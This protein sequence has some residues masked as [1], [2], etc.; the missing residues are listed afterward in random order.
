MNIEFDALVSAEKTRRLLQSSSSSPFISLSEVLV[1]KFASPHKLG[2][3]FALIADSDEAVIMGEHVPIKCEDVVI[4]DLTKY[5]S[6]SSSYNSLLKNLQTQVIARRPRYSTTVVALGE[7][8]RKLKGLLAVT[9]H[10][11]EKELNTPR[12][13][14][15]SISSDT[16]T[17]FFV[18][19]HIDDTKIVPAR[20]TAF[21]QFPNL[22]K[23]FVSRVIINTQSC[24][25]T[26]TTYFDMFVSTKRSENP[27]WQGLPDFLSTKHPFFCHDTYHHIRNGNI[28]TFDGLPKS[29]SEIENCFSIFNILLLEFKLTG[30]HLPAGG[31]IDINSYYLLI[32]GITW[33]LSTMLSTSHSHDHYMFRQS[34]V[35]PGLS[36]LEQKLRQGRIFTAWD[37]INQALFDLEVLSCISTLFR[38]ILFWVREVKTMNSFM[39]N[40]PKPT[41]YKTLIADVNPDH[42]YIPSIDRHLCD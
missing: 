23:K 12:L 8:D 26:A 33:F 39:T 17:A 2:T 6:H 27:D 13:P 9:F 5:S 42:A 31:F 24:A 36:I 37:D 38:L 3:I 32:H 28:T 1:N 15:G 20:G 35:N 25:A 30:L 14:F 16:P 18:P 34:L 29:T 7:V 10:G 11:R 21:L 41:T 19:H 22:D 4:S 40:P